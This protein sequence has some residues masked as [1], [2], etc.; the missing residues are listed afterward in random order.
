MRQQ[1]QKGNKKSIGGRKRHHYP[2]KR[3]KVRLGKHP[4]RRDE[5]GN[6][7]WVHCLDFQAVWGPQGQTTEPANYRCVQE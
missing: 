7:L 3:D 6:V 2:Q 1:Q 5:F 4:L